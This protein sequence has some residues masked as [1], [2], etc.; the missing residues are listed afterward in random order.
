M[1]RMPESTEVGSGLRIVPIVVHEFSLI[2]C[3]VVVRI[4]HIAGA[5]SVGP[6]VYCCEGMQVRTE[7]TAF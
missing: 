1:S 2:L 6:S 7:R 5:A 4:S 3:P